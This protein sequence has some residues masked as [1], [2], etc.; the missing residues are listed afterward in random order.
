[1]RVVRVVFQGLGQGGARVTG[2]RVVAG[3]RLV[4]PL[5]DDDV[6]LADQ[7]P[8]H[9][10]FGKRPQDVDV[11]DAEFDATGG[12]Q[13]IDRRLDVFRGGAQA[14]EDRVGVLDVVRADLAVVATGELRE[15]LTGLVEEPED[16]LDEVVP[17][18]GDAV[19]VVLLILDRA[20]QR[21][22]FQVDGLGHP[23]TLGP[24]EH[25][26]GLGRAVDDVVGRAEELAHKIR[27][28]LVERALE[29]G[30]QEPVLHV[31]ARRE[32]KFGDLA[33]DQ[34]LVGGLLR[35]L[36]EEDDPAGIERGVDVVVAAMDVERV[37]GERAGADLEHHRGEFAGSMVIL[38]DSVDDALAGGEIDRAFA[39]HRI[40]DGAALGRVF[41]LAFD[42]NLGAAED[43]EHALGVSLLIQFALFCR[44]RDRIKN[45]AVRYPGLGVVGNELVAVRRDAD[46]GILRIRSDHGIIR[47]SCGGTRG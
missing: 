43:V 42:R 37:L 10:R 31:D 13:V 33:Q 21:R 9:R 28:V 45:P 2:E 39:G 34:R 25:P 12:A 26:L 29:M 11:H 27:L 1:M 3:H 40:G 44:R 18:R 22:V 19:H 46:A 41:P 8:D 47:K 6:A 38:L 4:G 7:R 16:R 15:F 35:I 32:R 30:G 24:E 20:D 14:D 23:A 17:A 36:G 5:D